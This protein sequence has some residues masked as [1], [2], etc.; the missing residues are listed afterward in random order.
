MN[1][2]VKFKDVLK[3]KIISVP[4]STESHSHTNEEHS[5]ES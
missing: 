2:F 1:F 5:A 4:W 3:T